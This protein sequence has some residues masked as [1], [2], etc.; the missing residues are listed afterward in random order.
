MNEIILLQKIQDTYAEIDKVQVR[1]IEPARSL[2][3]LELRKEVKLWERHLA[4]VQRHNLEDRAGF[5]NL[6][7]NA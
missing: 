2:E 1:G 4:D 5:K 3:I 7:R 6:E